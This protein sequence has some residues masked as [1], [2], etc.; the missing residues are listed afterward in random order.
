[1]C[2]CLSA[3]M[4]NGKFHKFSF[5]KHGKTNQK[6]RLKKTTSKKCMNKTTMI[7]RARLFMEPFHFAAARSPPE[8]QYRFDAVRINSFPC[9]MAGVANAIASSGLVRTMRNSGPAAMT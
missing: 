6:A 7:V 8:R 1:M 3:Q 9:A 2:K 5:R 4:E